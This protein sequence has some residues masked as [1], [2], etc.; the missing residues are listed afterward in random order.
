MTNT[1]IL[2]IDPGAKGALALVEPKTRTIINIWDMPNY[3]EKLTTG[4]RKCTVDLEKLIGIF[5][6]IKTAAL[7][8]DVEIKVQIEKVQAFGRQSAPAAF[9]FGYAAAQPY[10]LAVVFGWDVAMVAPQS[11]KK[12]FGIIATKKDAA[13]L[14]VIK[15]FPKQREFFIRKMDVDRADAVLIAM[16]RGT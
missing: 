5:K 8:D 4:K 9:N 1:W 3:M 13:R 11:W 16:Y 6:T 14:L 7:G 12:Q 2:G 15:Y 10:V